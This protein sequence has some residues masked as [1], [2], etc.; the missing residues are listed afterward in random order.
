M[1]FL[2][3]LAL[4]LCLRSAAL[5]QS[6][7]DTKIVNPKECGK[8]N[9]VAAA[10]GRRKRFLSST[11]VKNQRDWGWLV[12]LDGEKSDKTGNLIN[13]QWVLTNAKR[14]EYIHT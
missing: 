6:A 14:V 8:I 13:S 5:A 2:L 10:Q 1:S 12:Y 9:S 4:S 7:N 11:L 3:I